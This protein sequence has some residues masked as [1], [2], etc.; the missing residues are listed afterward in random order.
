MRHRDPATTRRPGTLPDNL[1]TLAMALFLVA[2]LIGISG[3]VRYGS[4]FHTW[5][6]PWWAVPALLAYALELAAKRLRRFG[7][8]LPRRNRN[9][10]TTEPPTRS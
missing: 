1:N 2:G 6:T 4:F 10:L 7:T 3:M 9:P 5:E 8:V